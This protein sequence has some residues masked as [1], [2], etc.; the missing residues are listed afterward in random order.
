M[1]GL[2][3]VHTG[4]HRSNGTTP[5]RGALGAVNG[6]YSQQKAPPTLLATI[7]EPEVIELRCDACGALMSIGIEQRTGR[8]PFCDTP[9]VVT[10]PPA[11]GRPLPA[12]AL[13][14]VI[15]RE[16]AARAVKDWIRKRRMA[17][18]G[19]TRAAAE[20]IAG[21]YLPAYLY[22]ATAQSQYTA[23]IGEH[24][25]RIGLKRNDDGGVSIGRQEETEYRD[26]S[27]RRVSYVSD[28]LVTA[29]RSLS[30]QEVESIEP[31]DFTHLRRYSPLL[32]AGWTSEEPS[33]TPEH[34]LHLAQEEADA[35]V[36]RSLYGFMPGDTVRSLTHQTRLIDESMDLTLVPVWTFAMRYHPDKPAI[37]V[38]VNGQT[39]IPFSW[40]K[41]GLIF[42]AAA[43]LMALARIFASAYQ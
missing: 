38:L 37:R 22:S 35:S 4:S 40:E 12:F 30:N 15:E 25:R 17:P 19:L 18:F 34:C 16:D 13:G 23:S 42:L 9:S 6:R 5:V 7:K 24:Y 1:A 32:V 21:I 39:V 31:F 3:A 36:R 28:I 33:L 2:I 27:G 14:F 43:G 26:L 29:S 8:C 10:R 41:L 11:P 20:R